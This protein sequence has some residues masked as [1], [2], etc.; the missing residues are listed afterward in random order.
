MRSDQ[1]QPTLHSEP[2]LLPPEFC[3]LVRDLEPAVAS[4]CSEAIQAAVIDVIME[5]GF[6][7]GWGFFETFV[8]KYLEALAGKG[9]VP[10]LAEEMGRLIEF[11]LMDGLGIIPAE[12]RA[13]IL[14]SCGSSRRDVPEPEALQDRLPMDKQ[15]NK[16][17][18]G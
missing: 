7:E 8:F 17:R 9:P 14:A 11:V 5:N 2:K 13:R 1:H 12:M 10:W 16:E 6:G 3:G 15:T 18:K 4:D